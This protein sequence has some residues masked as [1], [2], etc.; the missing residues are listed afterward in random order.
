[1]GIFDTLIKR[2]KD[3]A[4]EQYRCEAGDRAGSFASCSPDRK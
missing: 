1:M 4:V 2:N 3:F